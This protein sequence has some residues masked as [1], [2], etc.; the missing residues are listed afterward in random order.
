VAAAAAQRRTQHLA[1]SWT[2]CCPCEQGVFRGALTRQRA[3]GAAR[4]QHRS[5]RWRSGRGRRTADGERRGASVGSSSSRRGAAAYRARDSSAPPSAAR[6]DR[7][8]RGVFDGQPP[9]RPPRRRCLEPRRAAT[10][11][12]RLPAPSLKMSHCKFEHPRRE[13]HRQMRHHRPCICCAYMRG[14]AASGPPHPGRRSPVPLTHR[15]PH[16]LPAA[17]ARGPPPRKGEVV[18][19]AWR[20]WQSRE[21]AER[22]AGEGQVDERE[23]RYVTSEMATRRAQRD[24]PMKTQRHL[25]QPHTLEPQSRS[26]DAR[27]AAGSP[28]T[29]PRSR[30]TS[31]P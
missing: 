31:R 3:A 19:V 4:R 23:L 26:A 27:L 30:S 13:W 9:P 10:P 14:C 18:S 5:E 20:Q 16:R 15:R 21:K 7:L 28:R 29:T 17:Q 8:G 24:R 12:S 6:R 25:R 11:S 22:N 1:Q 2:R